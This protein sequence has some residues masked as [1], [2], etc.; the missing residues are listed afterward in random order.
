MRMLVAIFPPPAQRARTSQ[1]YIVHGQAPPASVVHRRRQI[2]APLARELCNR[3]SYIVLRTWAAPVCLRRLPFLC[4]YARARF[5][6]IPLARAP[7]P[8]AT[9]ANSEIVHRPSYIVHRQTPSASV[10]HRPSYIG[11]S[12]ASVVHRQTPSASVVNRQTH[13]LMRLPWDH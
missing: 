4:N 9:R 8:R 3:T 2:P 13:F 11:A 5:D 10:V 1:S 7:H 12:S 6:D